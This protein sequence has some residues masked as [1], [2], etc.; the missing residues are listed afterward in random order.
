MSG[1]AQFDTSFAKKGI[2]NCTDS[3]IHG[4]KTK[5]WTLFTR[6][7]NPAIIGTLGGQQEFIEYIAKTFGAVPDSAWK[8]YKR[9]AILQVLKLSHELQCV[10]E[11]YSILQMDGQR[12]SATSYLIGQSWDGGRF[13]TFFD[14]QSDANA[15]RMVKPDLSPDLIVPPKKEKIEIL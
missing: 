7:S 1:N 4:F 8:L 10:V 14:S 11:L 3:L 6:Y 2:Q 12:I 13:W 9:G 5:N 15:A